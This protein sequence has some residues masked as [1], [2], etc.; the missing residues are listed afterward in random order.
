M[1]EGK[2]AEKREG[3]VKSGV[4]WG[5]EGKKGEHGGGRYGAGSPLIYQ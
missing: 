3:R 1:G 4:G 5:S 2:K